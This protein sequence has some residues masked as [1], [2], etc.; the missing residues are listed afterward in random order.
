MIWL[1]FDELSFEVLRLHCVGDCDG[2]MVYRG[3]YVAGDGTVDHALAI[4]Y[5]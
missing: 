3:D 4:Y 2:S 5:C 1:R